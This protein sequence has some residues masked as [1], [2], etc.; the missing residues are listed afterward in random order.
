M[1]LSSVYSELKQ[2]LSISDENFDL[3]HNINY[4]FNSESDENKLEIISDILSFINKFSMF[5]D[6]KPFMKSLY[7][8]INS[9]LEIKP[10]SIFDFE[11]LLI[12]NSIM[13]FVQEY[14]NYSKISQKDQVLEFLVESLEKLQIQPLIMNLGLLIKPLY[15]DQAYL[16]NL[17][18]LKE[19]EVAYNMTNGADIQIKNEIDSWLKTQEIKLENQDE[20][21]ELLKQEFRNIITKHNLSL[22]SEKSKKLE[23]EVIEMLTM[24]LT[25]LSL[26]EIIPDDSFEPIPIK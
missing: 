5:K 7:N 19:V 11:E 25:M 20:L 16:D 4:F 8:C 24:K 3:E 1:D 21:Y 17:E 26:M 6:I 10:D 15:H 2:L 14:L 18:D 13:H 9:T 12:K 22:D 23:K